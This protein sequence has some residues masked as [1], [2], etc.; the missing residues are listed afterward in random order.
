MSID[1]LSNYSDCQGA[2]NLFSSKT[3]YTS[4][5]HVNQAVCTAHHHMGTV[6]AIYPSSPITH[7]QEVRRTT[8]KDWKGKLMS[9]AV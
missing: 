4:H 5:E 7:A 3:S 8:G 6:S 1:A 9:S 2:V